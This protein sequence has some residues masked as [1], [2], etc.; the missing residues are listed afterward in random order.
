MT[1]AKRERPTMKRQREL[2][3]QVADLTT[4]LDA[5]EGAAGSDTLL[6]Q[7]ATIEAQA[8]AIR[9]LQEQL[10]A[11]LEDKDHDTGADLP[12]VEE[13]K[14]RFFTDLNKG[15]AEYL[16]RAAAREGRSPENMIER[17]IRIDWSRNKDQVL[18][19]PLGADTG[20]S[21]PAADLPP[22]PVVR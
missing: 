3:A 12:A 10:A 1:A 7:K 22:I 15:H 11:A 8:D 21:V 2:E 9:Q 20:T 18:Q 13:G 4:R 6:D 14:V 16:R 17:M 19:T 5:A